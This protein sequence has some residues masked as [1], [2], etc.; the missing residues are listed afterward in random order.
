MQVQRRL[1]SAHKAAHGYPLNQHDRLIVRIRCL[2]ADQ[3]L[4]SGILCE[5][6]RIKKCHRARGLKR[7][8]ILH[9]PNNGDRPTAVLHNRYGDDGVDQ[10]ILTGQGLGN[11]ILKLGR[12]EAGGR[13]VL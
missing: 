8:R 7:Q 11:G 13:Y 6:L 5:S 3:N 1:H 4:R 12:I 9:S 10:N 2:T